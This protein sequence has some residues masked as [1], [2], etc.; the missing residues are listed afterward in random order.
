ME[1]LPKELVQTEIGAIGRNYLGIVFLK[2]YFPSSHVFFS[3]CILFSFRTTLYAP[4]LCPMTSC[5]PFQGLKY[6][7]EISKINF[8]TLQQI[9][10]WGI[11]T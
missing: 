7:E 8:K 2:E 9:C 10:G 4:Y 1:I 11:K 3:D 6:T 5:S